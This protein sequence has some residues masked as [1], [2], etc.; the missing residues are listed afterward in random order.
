[1][2]TILKYRK[3]KDLFLIG[4]HV[5]ERPGSAANDH[6]DNNVV[7]GVKAAKHR[8]DDGHDPTG[9]QLTVAIIK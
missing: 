4:V 7:D 1:M 2:M 9:I 5:A 6:Y 8:T 3:S